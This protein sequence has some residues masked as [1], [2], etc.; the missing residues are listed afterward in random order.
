MMHFNCFWIYYLFNQ[1]F[2]YMHLL[3]FYC[4]FGEFTGKLLRDIDKLLNY[5]SYKLLNFILENVNNSDGITL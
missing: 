5:F 1:H 4:I 2:F 3:H